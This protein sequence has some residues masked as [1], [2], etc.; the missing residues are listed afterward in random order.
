MVSRANIL[1]VDDDPAVIATLGRILSNLGNV[2]FA[3]DGIE[4]LRLAREH[5]PDLVLLDI[6]M[7]AMD[8]FELCAA[9]KGDA[10]LQEIPVLFLT[11][12][13]SIEQEVTGL[14]LGAVDFLAKPSH[15]PLV[16]ARVGTQLRLK[17]M[18][19]ALR[20]EA[21]TDSLTCIA[22]R[23]H[24]EDRLE[25]EWQRSLRAC[26]PLSLVMI[27]IDH[28]KEFNDCYGHP[29]GDHCLKV[30]AER[31]GSVTHRAT[32]LL[33]R[34]GGEEFVALLP[35][36]DSTGAAGLAARLVAE[37]DALKLPHIGSPISGYLSISA[38]ASSFDGTCA[39]WMGSD[40]ESRKD[41]ARH[42]GQDLVAAAD[43]ALYAA[44][45][46]G[47]HQHRFQALDTRAD[48]D[49]PAPPSELGTIDE[50]D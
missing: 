36:T 3:T 34:F 35:G 13:D 23:R 44:K 24:F 31:L 2:R 29:A 22:N 30:V 10:I 17:R 26:T 8:G 25:R 16:V 50:P 46:G 48:S 43:Q 19:D 41:Q 14:A 5:P 33:A 27:D 20:L 7:P 40:L 37:I 38:G 11:S 32:D 42:G 49:L 47:R 4:A 12:H 15:A 9:M 21:T 45:S 28:F 39:G 6:E 18:T 1:L